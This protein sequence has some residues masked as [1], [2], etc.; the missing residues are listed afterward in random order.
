M[1]I[2]SGGTGERAV[3]DGEFLVIGA[4]YGINVISISDDPVNAA[5][6]VFGIRR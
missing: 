1:I 4:R 2:G 6:N 3:E 5:G